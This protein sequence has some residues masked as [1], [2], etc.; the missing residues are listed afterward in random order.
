M[1]K[2]LFLG[3]SLLLMPFAMQN[4]YAETTEK[5]TVEKSVQTVIFDMQNMT[6]AMCKFTIKKSLEKVN[7]VQ[8]VTVDSDKKTATVTFDTKK[9]S[10]EKLIKATTEA[11][12]PATIRK[13]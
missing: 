3:V 9:S 5:V 8:K 2:K 10:L 4:V 7:G 6:C 1:I 12:Y 13:K 11:G